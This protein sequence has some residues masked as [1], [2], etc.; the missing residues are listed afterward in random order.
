MRMDG[1]NFRRLFLYLLIASV[2]LSA[3][4]GIGVI[5]FGDF[6][7]FEVRVLMTTLTVTAASILGLACGA[8]L[9]QG[10]NRI[11]PLA[12]IFLSI[13]S[14]LMAFFI[15]W[16]VLDDSETFIKTFLSAILLA[17]ACSHLSL[18]MLAKL[19]RRFA[20]AR[21]AAFVCVGLLAA[22]LLYI[23]WVQPP[24]SNDIVAR[25]LGVLAILV[26]SITVVTPVF[27]KLSNVETG[28]EA[29]DTEI[30]KLRSRIEELEIER[31]RLKDQTPSA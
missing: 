4:F 28:I 23:I 8:Y 2:A 6:G 12:G 13:A 16:D 20:W 27:H 15:I 7:R 29:I 11:M 3:V 1:L 17:A 22:L 9:E 24:E 10:G 18:L 31:S 25:I 19:D 14:A 21:K 26:A 30:A 5:L